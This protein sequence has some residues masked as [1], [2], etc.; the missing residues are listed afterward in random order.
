MRLIGAVILGLLVACGVAAWAGDG[1]A[2]KTI[3]ISVTNGDVHD[4][5]ALIAKQGDLNI[6]VDAKV[7]GTVTVALRDVAPDEALKVVASAVGARVRQDGGVYV[8]D[9]KPLP[10]QRPETAP[11]GGGGATVVPPGTGTGVTNASAS[12]TASSGDEQIIRVLKLNYIDGAM[13]AAMFGGGVIGGNVQAFGGSPYGQGG[14][15]GGGYGGY[16]GGYG[17]RGNGGRWGYGGGNGNGYGTGY[18]GGFGNG[19]GSGSGSQLRGW[20]GYGGF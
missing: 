2:A 5:L 1:N 3:S 10:A 7:K 13:I 15:Y 14:G 9:P 20:G 11:A 19:Y 16:G 6:S 8:I 12:G 4:V 17:G 18:G